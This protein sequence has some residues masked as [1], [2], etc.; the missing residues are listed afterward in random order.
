MGD[1]T[2]LCILFFGL[3]TG[4]RVYWDT[5]QSTSTL[6]L[7]LYNALAVL[8]LGLAPSSA[9]LLQAMLPAE[10]VL[11]PMPIP[12]TS[13]FSYLLPVLVAIGLGTVRWRRQKYTRD[14]ELIHAITQY[15]RQQPYLPFLLLLFG[16]LMYFCTPLLPATIRQV[17]VFSGMVLWIGVL[18]LFFRAGPGE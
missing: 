7:F 12:A 14:Q 13:Y 17:G 2:F 5:L 3:I 9:Y 10:K 4:D 15:L 18:H 8:T 16:M 11:Q 1:A 6:Y